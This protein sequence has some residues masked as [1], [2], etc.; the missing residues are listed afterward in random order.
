VSRLL[1]SVV[2][3]CL[4]ANAGAAQQP[5]LLGEARTAIAPVAP[6][7]PVPS[8][9]AVGES[10]VA[11]RG[12]TFRSGVD[13]VALTVT[14]TD[15][16]QRYLPDL[17]AQDFAIFEDG[18]QQTVSYFGVADVPTDVALLVDGSISMLEKLPV[19]QDAAVGLLDALRP[20]DRASLVEFRSSVTITTPMTEDLPRVANA[21]RAMT[22]RGGTSLYN[23]VYV[24]L[25]EFDKDARA[26]PEIRRRAIVVLSDGEDTGSVVS[27][28]EVR[29][30]ARRSGVTFYSVGLKSDL[31]SAVT[32][33]PAGHRYFSESDY[34][35][36]ALADDT[37]ARAFFPAETR[38]LKGVYKAVGA[39]LAAQYAIGYISHNPIRNG[40]FR[41]L[42]VRVVAPAGARSR[43]RAGYFAGSSRLAANTQH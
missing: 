42:I 32:R 10:P 28:D 43:T 33:P 15:T 18:V 29:E 3:V 36:R 2:A 9:A 37:G 41:R 26:R 17:T 14:V 13:L 23:A 24:A 34:A 5:A 25:K 40:A 27:F 8:D 19:V 12:A 35:M 16:Q 38:D 22:A 7:P 6:L 30:L 39:E 4:T 11:P 1:W 20:G 31:L 21:V